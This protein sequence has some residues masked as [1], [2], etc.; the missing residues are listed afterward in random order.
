MVPR[1]APPIAHEIVTPGGPA[2]A[3]VSL[4]DF[5][6]LIVTLVCLIRLP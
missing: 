5:T 4:G 3:S 1:E 6:L 2:F